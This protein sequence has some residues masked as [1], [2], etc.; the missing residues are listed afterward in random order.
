MA[1]VAAPPGVELSA[2]PGTMFLLTNSG[3]MTQHAGSQL[4]RAVEAG[5]APDG[6][7]AA[8][9]R[10]LRRERARGQHPAGSAH[11]RAPARSAAGAHRFEIF[12]SLTG[13]WS[14]VPPTAGPWQVADA[15]CWVLPDGRL[16]VGGLS[17]TSYS[18]YD[19]ASR[20]WTTTRS[21]SSGGDTASTRRRAG[22]APVVIIRLSDSRT[23]TV[24]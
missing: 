4:W 11:R 8:Q 1:G 15:L 3:V 6:P 14:P 5:T 24:G 17:S 12:D 19:P 7:T 20:R 21:D 9:L 10:A 23:A 22:A 13:R 2:T 18:T 16:L